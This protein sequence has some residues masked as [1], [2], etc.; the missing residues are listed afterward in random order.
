MRSMSYLAVFTIQM[1]IFVLAMPSMPCAL[2]GSIATEPTVIPRPLKIAAQ[3]GEFVI[4]PTTTIVADRASESIGGYLS[5]V[6]A[7]A[8]AEN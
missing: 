1:A 4:R 8:L 6:L 7:P 5:E 2:T 3:P